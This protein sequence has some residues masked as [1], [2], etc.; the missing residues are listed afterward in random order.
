MNFFPKM[1]G[2][3]LIPNDSNNTATEGNVCSGP[4]TEFLKPKCSTYPDL[5]QHNSARNIEP[6]SVDFPPRNGGFK[7]LLI[8]SLAL[9]HRGP[10]Q[11][12]RATR[13]TCGP[14]LNLSPALKHW[15]SPNGKGYVATGPICRP[16]LTLS[17]ALKHWGP[18]R[19][20][21]LCSHWAHL[22]A[23]SDFVSRSEA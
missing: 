19:R 12:A 4:R 9:K 2:N 22:W 20:R 17:P 16:H 11:T 15:L 18:P 23:T 21:G 5:C 6:Q 10:P 3:I 1:D 13:P 14:L 8:L 7:D